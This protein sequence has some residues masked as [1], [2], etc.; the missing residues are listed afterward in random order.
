MS[1]N[2]LVI[3][4][5]KYT[6]Q[7]K[8]I[9]ISFGDVK[10]KIHKTLIICAHNIHTCKLFVIVCKTKFLQFLPRARAINKQWERRAAAATYYSVWVNVAHSM[11]LWNKF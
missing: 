1:I 5:L 9:I 11:A 10:I 4:C 8:K 7:S 2:A 3:N 6:S